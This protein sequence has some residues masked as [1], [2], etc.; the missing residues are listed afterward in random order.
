M[1]RF[2]PSE[3]PSFIQ[4]STFARKWARLRLGDNDLRA[5]EAELLEAIAFGIDRHPILEG[6]GGVRKARV[7]PP[8]QARGKSG[9]YR[10]IYLYL[11]VHG[12]VYLL[13][14]YGKNEK[15]NLSRGERNDVARIVGLIKAAHERRNQ[16]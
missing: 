16:G 8:G 10:A 3:L 5:L 9:A 4:T 15:S 7:V 14:A 2:K 11:E 12:V 13:T 1:E 6:T